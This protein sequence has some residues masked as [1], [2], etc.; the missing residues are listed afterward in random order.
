MWWTDRA[1]SAEGLFELDFFAMRHGKAYRRTHTASKAT[2]QTPSR[3]YTDTLLCSF[4][5]EPFGY[6]DH[7]AYFNLQCHGRGGTCEIA[8]LSSAAT[9]SASAAPCARARL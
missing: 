9:A 7:K 5:H 4:A 2:S 6:R 3:L 1:R 8:V